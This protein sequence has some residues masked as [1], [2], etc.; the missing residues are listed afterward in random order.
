MTSEP[1]IYRQCASVFL[2]QKV[3]AEPLFLLV[4]KPRTADAWQL[5]QGGAEMG[6]TI[7]QAA[8]RELQEETNATATLLGVST[9]AYQYD[10]PDSFR[11]YRPDNVIGQRVEFVFA[12]VQDAQAIQVDQHEIDDYKWITLT[13]LEEYVTRPEY[14]QVVHALHAQF[15]ELYV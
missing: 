6:E 14:I 1:M 9:I 3:Q 8:V 15:L 11:S 4:H 7:T 13:E 12:V 2:V 5:P 10:F